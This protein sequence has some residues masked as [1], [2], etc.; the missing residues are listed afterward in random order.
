MRVVSFRRTGNGPFDRFQAFLET[1]WRRFCWAV[2]IAAAAV[3]IT[4]IATGV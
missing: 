4:L 3:I 1:Y 2:C